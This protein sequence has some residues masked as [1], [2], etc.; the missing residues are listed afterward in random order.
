[1]NHLDD[2]IQNELLVSLTLL[3]YTYKEYEKDGRVVGLDTSEEL[4]ALNDAYT[5]C[6]QIMGKIMENYSTITYDDCMDAIENIT[7]GNQTPADVIIN[8]NA[9]INKVIF[10]SGTVTA[11]GKRKRIKRKTHKNSKRIKRI[12]RIKRKSHRRSYRSKKM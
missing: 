3:Q 1:M 7:V 12:K 11:I 9:K 10:N 6:M 4:K 2:T 8:F 5:E